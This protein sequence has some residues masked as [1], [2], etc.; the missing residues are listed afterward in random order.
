MTRH[1]KVTC[2]VF[3]TDPL[4]KKAQTYRRTDDNNNL[5]AVF[6]IC[7]NTCCE[8]TDGQM[9]LGLDSLNG[10]ELVTEEPCLRSDAC[11]GVFLF[12]AAH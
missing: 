5:G 10:R 12:P 6:S 2:I 4:V 1:E 11:K 9:G 3:C 7:D 8:W